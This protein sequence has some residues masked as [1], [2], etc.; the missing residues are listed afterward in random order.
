MDPQTDILPKSFMC[1]MTVVLISPA[2]YSID[3]RHSQRSVTNVVEI[4][5]DSFGNQLAE[6]F[7]QVAF[8]VVGKPVETQLFHQVPPLVVRACDAK[9]LA[10]LDFGNLADYRAHSARRPRYH[11]H[12]AGLGLANLQKSEVRGRPRHPQNPQKVGQGEA[13][14]VRREVGSGGVSR[15]LDDTRQSR[16]NR[17]TSP[18]E[19]PHHVLTHWV[20]T[21]F[22][23]HHSESN[24]LR[25][26]GAFGGGYR[27]TC[28]PTIVAPKGMLCA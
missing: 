9:R 17:V 2:T 16:R 13:F 20:F 11:D 14:Q 15:P 12:L 21:V 8:L 28:V 23:V 7:V 6:S 4:T 10:T 18:V 19:F 1:L 5:V 24:T 27:A 25:P 3:K 26:R 22:A